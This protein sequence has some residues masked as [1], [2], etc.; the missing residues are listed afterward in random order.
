[1]I[2]LKNLIL[3]KLVFKNKTSWNMHHP[4]SSSRH[5]SLSSKNIYCIYFSINPSKKVKTKKHSEHHNHHNPSPA[6]QS[7]ASTPL[8]RT[9]PFFATSNLIWLSECFFL[10]TKDLSQNHHTISHPGKFWRNSTGSYTK[11]PMTDSHGMNGSPLPIHETKKASIH[12]G[13]YS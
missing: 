9:N 11:K 2:S 10:A 13:K 8:S 6:F 5:I 12:V 7:S 4:I 1:M 3:P